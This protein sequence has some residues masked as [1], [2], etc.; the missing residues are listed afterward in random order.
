MDKFEHFLMLA[1][2]KVFVGPRH[3]KCSRDQ[4]LNMFNFWLNI[5]CYLSHLTIFKDLVDNTLMMKGR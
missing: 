1:K 5:F 2:I 3:L 4:K